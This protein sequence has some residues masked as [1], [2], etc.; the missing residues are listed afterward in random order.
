MSQGII[1]KTPENGAVGRRAKAACIAAPNYLD[2]RALRKELTCRGVEVFSPEELDLPGRNVAEVVREALR[3][4]D[5]VV[6]V[7][8]RTA[9]SSVVF[10]EIG[11]AQALEKPTFALLLGDA[12]PSPWLASSVPYFRFD[13][14]IPLGLDFAVNQMLAAPHH[15]SAKTSGAPRRTQPLGARADRLLEQARASGEEIGKE[16]FAAIVTS[17]I[18]ESGVASVE[19]GDR[20]DRAVDLVVWSDDLSPWVGNPLAVELVPRWRRGGDIAAKATPMMQAMARY[21]IPWGLLIC[22]FSDLEVAAGPT[23]PNVIP[24][25]LEHFLKG[26]RDTGFGDLVRML[27]NRRVHGGL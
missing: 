6:A 16:E 20:A 8:D 23:L 1:D 2:T 21:G 12:S 15:G 7:V 3:R 13:P 14:E 4:A 10:Y 9:D 18:R 22:G 5:L 19:Q 11:F 24:V 26:L 25:S 17:A 27:R